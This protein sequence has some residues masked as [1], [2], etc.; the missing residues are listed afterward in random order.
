M[1]NIFAQICS[2]VGMV[3]TIA[4]FQMKTRKQILVFQTIGSTFFMFSYFLFG[5]LTGVYINVV[6]L[7]RNTVFYLKEDKKWAQSRIWLWV[8]MIASVVAAALGY[9]SPVDLCPMFG[10]LF[11]TI[12]LYMKQENLIRLLNLISCPCWLFY[13]INMTST[14]GVIC[15]VFNIVSI[16]VALIRYK[17]D[18]FRTKQQKKG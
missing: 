13:N 18:G 4:S 1:I 3:I 9:K 6:Y 14:G 11:A 7:C 10:A 17:K 8:F 5:S 12:A 16:I 15:D 2:I